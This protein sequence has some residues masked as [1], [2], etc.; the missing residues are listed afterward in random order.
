MV[1]FLRP[2]ES[3]TIF[4]QQ[5][6]RGLR[7]YEGKEYV[8][9]LDFIGNNYDRSI[10]MAMALGTLGQS[11]II[12]KPYLMDLVNTDFKALNL[13]GVSIDIDSLSKE[14]II[15]YIKNENF[16]T[17]DFLIKDYQNFKKY[18]HLDTYPTHMDYI[19]SDCSPNLMRL[20]KSKNKW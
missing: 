15:N 13:P 4:L 8:T 19:N 11:S 1:L 18:L 17:K 2:T 9:V 3:Q 12:E 6:G 16:N 7:K 14:E 20:I 10:Q 5:L